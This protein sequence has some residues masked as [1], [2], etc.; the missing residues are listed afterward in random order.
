MLGI[1]SCPLD[2]H[3]AH[4]SQ[5]LYI[6][7]VCML[8]HCLYSCFY[9]ERT[10]SSGHCRRNSR[11]D[12]S[13]DV[14]GTEAKSQLKWPTEM[15]LFLNNQLHRVFSSYISNYAYNVIFLNRSLCIAC[16][17]CLG[18]FTCNQSTSSVCSIRYPATVVH[19]NNS[20]TDITFHSNNCHCNTNKIMFMFC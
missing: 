17:E 9:K 11:L 14:R 5:H 20:L 19:Y 2:C 10:L 18:Y 15:G 8:K 16:L 6:Y 3:M 12:V 1:Q 13:R 4:H 7:Q